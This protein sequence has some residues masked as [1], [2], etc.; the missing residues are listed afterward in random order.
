MKL[1]DLDP[2]T[3]M[4][5]AELDALVAEWMGWRLEF[6]PIADCWCDDAGNRRHSVLH[7][8]PSTNPADAGEARRKAKQSSIRFCF[9]Q[10][11]IAEIEGYVSA[12]MLHETDGHGGR[13]EALATSRALAAAIKAKGK[14]HADS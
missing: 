14:K 12:C 1:A 13:A 7:W 4:A 8:S 5:S 2:A 10:G 3:M 9:A 6:F 11:F